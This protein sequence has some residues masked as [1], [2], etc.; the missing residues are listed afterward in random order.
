M[1]TWTLLSLFWRA[2]KKWLKW[3]GEL[4]NP[5]IG[6]NPEKHDEKLWKGGCRE[7]AIPTQVQDTSNLPD[8]HEKV[9]HFSSF[10]NIQEKLESTDLD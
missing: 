6:V 7:T 4:W 8:F 1:W 5:G 3:F 2:F 10:P 9:T